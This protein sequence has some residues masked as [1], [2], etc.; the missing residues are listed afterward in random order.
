M[1]SAAATVR[2]IPE[3]LEQILI[4]VAPSRPHDLGEVRNCMEAAKP[5]ASLLCMK[6][7]NRMWSHIIYHSHEIQRALFFE[8]DSRDQG[9]MTW[10][11]EDEGYA[12]SY[13]LRPIM[14]A[15]D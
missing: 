6:R 13:R 10:T 5:L 9:P 8:S 7:V 4:Q 14:R 11:I 12:V 2:G 1:A 15:S 3:L